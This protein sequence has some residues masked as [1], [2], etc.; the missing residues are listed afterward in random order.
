MLPRDIRRYF[1]TEEHAERA[2]ALFDADGNGD[3][4][5]EEVENACV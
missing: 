1:A 5:K 4:S 3:A 2:F